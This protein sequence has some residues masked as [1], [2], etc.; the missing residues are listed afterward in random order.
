MFTALLA[1]VKCL[2]LVD[3]VPLCISKQSSVVLLSDTHSY[4]D[5]ACL[6]LYD[7]TTCFGCPHQ[8]SLVRVWV[9]FLCFSALPDDG[10]CGQPKYVVISKKPNIQYIYIYIIGFIG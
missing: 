8:P 6:V 10:L 3:I 1:N 4:I 5:L 9:V 7:I 2:I